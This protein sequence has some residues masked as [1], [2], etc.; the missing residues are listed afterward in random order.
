MALMKDEIEALRRG[1]APPP[2]PAPAPPLGATEEEVRALR[3]R[4]VVLEA[5]LQRLQVHESRTAMLSQRD[6]AEAREGAAAEVAR[7][8]DA[9]AR[10][11]AAADDAHAQLSTALAERDAALLSL[12]QQVAAAEAAAAAKAAEVARLQEAAAREGAVTDDAH[13]QLSAA[14]A[15]RDAALL[16]LREQV[17][18]AQAAAA[19]AAARAEDAE[20][21]ADQ[22][23]QEISRASQVRAQ[24]I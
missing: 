23:H 8:Q 17:A 1:A 19:A 7:V 24:L 22:S 13:A 4:I 6:V 14:L 18:A 12:R 20:V 3:A 16:S 21:R 15:E 2:T 9:A 10:A 11:R 5:D